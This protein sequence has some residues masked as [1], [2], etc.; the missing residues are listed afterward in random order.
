MVLLDSDK[1]GLSQKKRYQSIFGKTIEDRIFTYKDID[2]KWQNTETEDL[3]TK[4]DKL[5]IQQAS[6]PNSTRIHKK[7][8]N[9]SIQELYV[10]NLKVEIEEQTKNNLKKVIKFLEDKLH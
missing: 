2:L 9:R 4:K 10:K 3:F 1:G 7:T 6:Y 8:F 5:T